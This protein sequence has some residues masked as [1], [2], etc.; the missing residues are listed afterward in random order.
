MLNQYVIDLY[1]RTPLGAKVVVLASDDRA[2]ASM[3]AAP[4]TTWTVAQPPV[5]RQQR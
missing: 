2:A 5:Y 4:A 1:Q 3:S